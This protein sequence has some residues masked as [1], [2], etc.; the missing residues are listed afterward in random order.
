MFTLESED[1]LLIC[2]SPLKVTNMGLQNAFILAAFAGLAQ[3]CTIFPMIRWG[4]KMRESSRAR[5]YKY[6]KESTNLG[7]VH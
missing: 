4:R 7:L 3:V 2:T 5:Y 1:N 6:V